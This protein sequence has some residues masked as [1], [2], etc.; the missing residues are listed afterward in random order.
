MLGWKAVVAK[1]LFGVC[2]ESDSLQAICRIN[3][4]GCCL[5][6][7]GILV[8]EI[9]RISQGRNFMFRFRPREANQDAHVVAKFVV[10]MV[11]EVVWESCFPSFLLD[12]THLDV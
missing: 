3:S 1:N 5:A 6:P 8:E 10:S 11:G 9:K 7:D 4:T 12:V 2:L